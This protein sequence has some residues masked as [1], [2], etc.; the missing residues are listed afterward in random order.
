MTRT[1]QSA[2]KSSGGLAPRIT[3]RDPHRKATCFLDLSDDTIRL[4]GEYVNGDFDIPLP[5]F[6]PHWMNFMSEI[7]GTASKNL[8]HLRAT[9]RRIRGAVFLQNSHIVLKELPSTTSNQNI[10]IKEASKDFKNTISR[11]LISFEPRKSKDPIVF[12]NEFTSTL[13]DMN[14]E[15]LIIKSAPFCHH[16]DFWS[17]HDIDGADET[18]W[19]KPLGEF[20]HRPFGHIFDSLQS[21]SIETRCPQCVADLPLLFVPAARKLGHLRIDHEPLK[22]PLHDEEAAIWDPDE[23]FKAPFELWRTEHGKE[24]GL[25]TLHIHYVDPRSDLR[26]VE[27]SNVIGNAF[28]TFRQLEKFSITR[29]QGIFRHLVPGITLKVFNRGGG[30]NF[31]ID[32]GLSLALT[33]LDVF[34]YSLSAPPTLKSFDPVF[35]L[36]IGSGRPCISSP[37]SGESGPEFFQ[38]HEL[39]LALKARNQEMYEPNLMNAM[40]AVSWKMI[41][42]IPSLEEGA[43]WEQGTDS[44]DCD[45]YRWTWKKSSNSDGL[46]SIEIDQFPLLLSRDFVKC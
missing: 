8:T 20:L 30:W 41:D 19:Y 40:K 23:A 5:S 38:K 13:G 36:R 16:L 3:T 15:E 22:P 2:R 14:L 44:T 46:I 25:K 27:W 37:I 10:W 43:F 24:M 12:W 33:S 21:L 28:S 45:W 17:D 4:I 39:A 11:A 1:K 9:C 35:R 32:D 7:G 18:T 42:L 26:S 34:I 6:G 31:E 29:T